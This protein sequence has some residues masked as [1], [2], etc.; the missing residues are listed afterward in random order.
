MTTRERKACRVK[1][2]MHKSCC[3]QSSVHTYKRS[4]SS[5]EKVIK[6]SFKP[7]AEGDQSCLFCFMTLCIMKTK[8]ISVFKTAIDH[9]MFF[10]FS[11]I[12]HQLTARSCLTCFSAYFCLYSRTSLYCSVCTCFVPF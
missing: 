4:V 9:S 11:T 10:F 3:S 7:F 2:K 12:R 6:L 1:K 5:T 8:W